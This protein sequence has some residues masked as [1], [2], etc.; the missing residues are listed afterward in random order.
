MS[1]SSDSLLLA[2]SSWVGGLLVEVRRNYWANYHSMRMSRNFK[3]P[4]IQFIVLFSA[5]VVPLI[6]KYLKTCHSCKNYRLNVEVD[7]FEPHHHRGFSVECFSLAHSK[8]CISFPLHCRP[9]VPYTFSE[10]IVTLNYFQ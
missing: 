3:P 2:A 10:C 7:V 6:K 4:N 5:I 8:L 1:L 9:P